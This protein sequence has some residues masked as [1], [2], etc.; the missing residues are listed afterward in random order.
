MADLKERERRQ[1]F[2]WKETDVFMLNEGVCPLCKGDVEIVRLEGIPRFFRDYTYMNTE[3]VEREEWSVD[4]GRTRFVIG[5]VTFKCE[6]G[7]KH[8][9]EVDRTGDWH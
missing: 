6:D 2:L 9:I 1:E 5:A 8:Y 7:H 4:S 3:D